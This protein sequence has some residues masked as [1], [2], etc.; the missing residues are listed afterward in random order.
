MAYRSR[1]ASTA[2]RRPAVRAGSYS[3]R[4][5]TTRQPSRRRSSSGTVRIVIEQPQMSQVARPFQ[6]AAPAPKQSKF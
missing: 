5:T 6:V 4:R 3:R 1:R 2:R